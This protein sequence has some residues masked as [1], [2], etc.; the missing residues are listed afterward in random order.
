LRFLTLLHPLMKRRLSRIEFVTPHSFFLSL[1]S[2]SFSFS[3]SL[4][5]LLD[6]DHVFESE[7]CI[8]FILESSSAFYTINQ[9]IPLIKNFEMNKDEIFFLTVVAIKPVT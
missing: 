9:S 6:S 5:T 8:C 7:G 2:L 1:C 4:I 3:F